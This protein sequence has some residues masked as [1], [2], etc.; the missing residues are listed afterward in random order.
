MQRRFGT[1]DL[2]QVRTPEVSLNTDPH[3]VAERLAG[4]Y[5]H[6]V[7]SPPMYPTG[8]AFSCRLR[9]SGADAGVVTDIAGLAESLVTAPDTVPEAAHC[10]AAACFADELLAATGDTR[11]RDFLIRQAD[12]FVSDPDIRVEDFFFA[13][14]LLG[15]AHRVTGE[16]SYR[17]RLLE[18]LGSVDTRQPNGLYWHCH[19]SPYFWGR[20]NAFAAL[21][22]A[23]ALSYLGTEDVG[24]VV[25]THEQHLSSLASHQDDSG[26]WRQLI[27]DESTYLEHSATTMIGIAIVQGLRGGWLA[28]DPW[29]EVAERA[30]E[31]AASRIGVDGE[32]DQ[33]CIGTGP[34]ESRQAYFER[35]FSTGTDYRGGAMALWFAV[36]MVG[37]IEGDC[38]AL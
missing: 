7:E 11:Y 24:D 30:W 21:G 5:G 18:F 4:I 15:R 35:P 32:L 38:A 9:L 8:I 31:G 28:D 20:G 10:L 16:A 37:L 19:A 23:Q 25:A 12:R 2:L 17:D 33:V 36:E 1:E 6:A 22:F 3:A 14:T 29:R 26:L 34:L 13:G 27:D